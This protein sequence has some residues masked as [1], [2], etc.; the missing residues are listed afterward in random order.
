MFS[1][2]LVAQVVEQ[3]AGMV[4]IYTMTFIWDRRDEYRRHIIIR[5]NGDFLYFVSIT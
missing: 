2:L 3:T 4:V 1:S 5:Y